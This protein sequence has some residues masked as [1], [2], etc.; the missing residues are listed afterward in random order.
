MLLNIFRTPG[1]VAAFS[2]NPSKQTDNKRPASDWVPRCAAIRTCM[3]AATNVVYDWSKLGLLDETHN[4]VR[5]S[6]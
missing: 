2:S 3:V 1:L 4:E 6:S 5:S